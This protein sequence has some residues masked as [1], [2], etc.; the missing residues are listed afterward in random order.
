VVSSDQGVANTGHLQ[1]AFIDRS[2]AAATDLT[3]LHTR[4]I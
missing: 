4:R 3:A 1:D 2:V